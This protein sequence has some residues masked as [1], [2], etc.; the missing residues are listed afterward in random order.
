[1]S[2][3]SPVSR[4]HEIDALLQSALDM[5]AEERKVLIERVGREQPEIASHLRAMLACVDAVDDPLDALLDQHLWAELADDPAAGQCFG[6]WRARGTIAHGGMARVLFAERATGGFEQ[7]AAIKCLWPGLASPELIARFEQERQILARLDDPRIARLLDGGVRADGMPWLA[8]E[9]VSG[10]SIDEHC[11]SCCLSIDERIGLWDEVAIAVASAH[12]RLIVHRDLKPSNVLVNEQGAIKLLDFGIAKL[13]D[14]EGFPAAAPPTRIEARALTRE[15]A[16]PEQLRGD[17]I[18][19]ASDVYQLG[20]LLFELVCG[21][22]PFVDTRRCHAEDEAL[23]LS[24][25][26]GQDNE[27]DAHAAQRATTS[28]RLRRCLRG[29]FDAI[30]QRALAVSPAARYGSVDAMREDVDRWQRGVPVRA[31]RIGRLRRSGK[32]LRRHALLSVGIVCVLGLTLAY[33]ISTLRQAQALAREAGINRTVRDYLVG[34]FQAADPGGTQGQD[35]RASEMLVDGLA[36]VRRDV[37]I[38]PELKAEMLN[39]IGEIHLARGEMAQAEPILLEANALYRQLPSDEDRLRGSSSS[40]LALLL[41]YSG[42]YA[43]SATMYRQALDERIASVGSKSYWTIVTRQGYADVLHSLGRYR[44][45]IVQLEHAL[46]DAQET[47][48]ESDALVAVLESSIANVDRDFGRQRESAERYAKALVVQMAAHGETHPNTASSRL[49]LGRL[50]LDQGNYGDAAGQINAAFV[51]FQKT[52]GMTTPSTAY[53]ERV[54]AQLL[55]ANGDLESAASRLQRLERSMREQL[56]PGHIITAYL[57]IDLGFV[58]LERGNDGLA[59]EWFAQ[60]ERIFNAIQPEGHPRRIEILLG[61]GLLAARQSNSAKTQAL[62]DA[63]WAQAVR[64]LDAEHPLFAA[65]NLARGKSGND[66][67]RSPG[68]ASLR[69]SRAL[70]SSAMPPATR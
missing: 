34:W 38:H 49:G 39:I 19:T 7:F 36:R 31:R 3:G 65:I 1:M 57:Q 28:A 5:D 16:S 9:Y 66:S 60:A 45:A 2:G 69:V 59:A 6:S 43:E 40:S 22:R 62:L 27:A 44:E 24:A 61:Q 42:R 64:Q 50:L 10:R 26:I 35:P 29:D 68:L 11:N 53:C 14:A 46:E 4:F 37:T 13:L 51:T 32:W 17:A 48:G 25:A 18:T 56:P 41:H 58:E 67:S 21:V 55:E 52:R 70:A 47:L 23:S 12:Q 63:A 33:A 8:L 20:V 15:Y 30:L 54:V